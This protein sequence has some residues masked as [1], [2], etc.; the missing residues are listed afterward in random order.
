MGS[1]HSSAG[2]VS[3]FYVNIFFLKVLFENLSKLLL[4]AN[5]CGIMPQ[6]VFI[7][8]SSLNQEREGSLISHL[9]EEG[10]GVLQIQ[11]S[12]VKVKHNIGNGNEIFS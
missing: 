8:S 10:V 7:L 1:F 3:I 11:Y 2:K 9:Y 4:C 6:T 12:I 5:N